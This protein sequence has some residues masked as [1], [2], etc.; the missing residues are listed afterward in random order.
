M[1]TSST[2]DGWR[3]TVK[4]MSKQLKILQSNLIVRDNSQLP[5]GLLAQLVKHGTGIA[6]I[7]GSK[8]PP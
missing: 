2:Q 3:T 1:R 6:E 5:V 4:D 7:M 8:I